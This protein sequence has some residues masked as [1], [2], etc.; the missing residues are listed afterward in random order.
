MS[1]PTGTV[2]F[3]FTDIVGSTP[4]WE[5]QPEKMAVA[6]QI[7]NAALRTAIEANAGTVFKIVGDAFQTAFHTAL[8]GLKAAIQG[9]RNLQSA[10]WNE[11]APLGVRMGLHTGEALLVAQHVGRSVV[12]QIVHCL[13]LSFAHPALPH[14]PK[15]PIRVEA[16]A[17]RIRPTTTCGIIFLYYSI[18]PGHKKLSARIAPLPG[19][20]S[21]TRPEAAV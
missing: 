20:L 9:Q 15:K 16:M 17:V 5:L 7:H 8:D 3:L 2:T 19:M 4:L 1:L 6:L 10:A 14:P 12:L 13:D 18:W 21:T 11:L